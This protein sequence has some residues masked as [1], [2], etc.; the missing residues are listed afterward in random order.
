MSKFRPRLARVLA[1]FLFLRI[2]A[3]IPCPCTLRRVAFVWPVCC[4]PFLWP[5]A[6][7]AAC[8]IGGGGG[9]GGGLW[10]TGKKKT[11]GEKD[12]FR[13]GLW[14]VAAFFA[15]RLWPVASVA[16]VASAAASAAACGLCLCLCGLCLCGG[17]LCLWRFAFGGLWRRWRFATF[18]PLFP[19]P[20]SLRPKLRYYRKNRNAARRRRSLC[21][22]L[23]AAA[24]CACAFAV[25]CAAFAV[26]AAFFSAAAF[27][28]ACAPLA[29]CAF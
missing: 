15:F 18:A 2:L 23:Y 21:G 22:G 26:A 24:A 12:F 1:N 17:G 4:V 20:F 9:I 19:V 3:R 16:A 7:V 8:G 14:P 13:C 28:A 25:A 27:A 11:G 10:K 5:V 6:S 29:A